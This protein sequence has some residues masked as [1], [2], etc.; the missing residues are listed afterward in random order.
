MKGPAR[1]LVLYGALGIAGALLI[2]IAVQQD[3]LEERLIEQTK[4]TAALRESTQRITEQLDR[5]QKEGVASSGAVATSTEYVDP[6]AKILHPEVKNFLGEKQLRWPDRAATTDGTLKRGWA[7]GDPRTLNSLLA[8]AAEVQELITHYIDA[9]P[10]Q[11]NAFTDPDIFYGDLA[12]R[13]E[14]TDDSKEFTIYL[15][16]GVKWHT[17]SGVD[18]NNPKYAW[19]KGDHELTAQDFVF[20]LDLMMNPQV[21]NGSIKNYYSDL[22]SWKA[23]DD[24]TLVLRWKRRVFHAAEYSLVSLYPIPRF[25]FEHNE[26]GSKIGKETLGTRLNN[27]WYNLKG[28]VGVGP[29]RMVRYEPGVSIVLE[30]NESYY[31][32][33]PA[34]KTIVYPIYTDTNQTVLKLKAKELSVGMLMPSQ[35][36]REILDFEKLPKAQQPKDNPFLNGTLSCQIV[37]LPSF[38]YIGWNALRSPF[39]DVN[40][41]KAMTYALNREAIIKDVFVGLGKVAR[42]PFLESSTD[43]DPSIQPLPFDLQEAA[44]LLDAAGWK[45]TNQDGLRDKLVGGR[46]VALEFSLL[47]Y[48]TST[49]YTALANI[50]K[51]DLLKIGAKLNI[52]AAEWSLMQKRIHEKDFDGFIGGWSM[53]WTSD[54][55]QLWHS[56][57]A[58]AAEG[59]NITSFKNPEADRLMEKLRE[60]IEP[61]TRQ[62]ILH[63]LHRMIVDSYNYTFLSTERRPFCHHKEVKG[64]RFAKMRPVADALPWWVTQN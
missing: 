37:D 45:D 44:K 5:I 38:R 26:D 23:I 61:E 43:L 59:S 49:E 22:E 60:T 63:Q 41:R 57:Q 1:S 20:T 40:V 47:I 25:I 34:V 52:E 28:Y 8:N 21:E 33:K 29:Y 10:A 46:N 14:V 12:W 13:V 30:R 53:D 17:A 56:S 39:S 7:S 42:G 18:L 16:R 54:P 19:L 9:P 58:D 31:G 3:A 50:F 51:E 32:D 27:H 36:R 24:Y 55:Y 4:A 48:A 2:L 11:R 62:A 64:V 6:Q 15:R 35:Y